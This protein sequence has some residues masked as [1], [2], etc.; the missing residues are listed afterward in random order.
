MI[1]YIFDLDDTI[2]IHKKNQRLNYNLIQEDKELSNLIYNCDK[3]GKCYIYTNG[4]GLHALDVMKKMNIYQ[5][6]EKIYSRD[7]IP[8]MK[9]DIRSFNDVNNDIINR[10][11]NIN[12]NIFFDDLLQ[13]LKTAHSLGWITVLINPEIRDNYSFVNYSFSDLKSALLYLENNL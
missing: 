3:K 8:Y 5:Y 4:T 1:N 12:K 9:P 6:F 11:N 13:N 10:Y 7:T 2:I